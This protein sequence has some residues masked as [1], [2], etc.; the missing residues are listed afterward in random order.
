MK[1]SLRLSYLVAALGLTTV[2][3]AASTTIVN[4]EHPL[5]T[6]E[7]SDAVAS[8]YFIRPDAGFSGVM[9]KPVSIRVAGEELLKL[10]KGQY[11]LV[12]LKPGEGE[13]VVK[14]WTVAMR[15]GTNSMMKV[16]ESRPF[17]FVAGK[18][19]YVVV[20]E[21]NRPPS[22]GNSF[23]PVPIARERALEVA[24]GLIPVGAAVDAPLAR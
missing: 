12:R 4:T 7:V 3:E 10:A 8:V 24:A 1:R 20:A 16:E 18:Q 21:A 11:T 14:S 19:Y 5:L 13:G 22:E 9:G 23:P 15:G 17:A 2:V 6:A